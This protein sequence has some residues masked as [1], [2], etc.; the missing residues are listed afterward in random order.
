M[1]QAGPSEICTHRN[2]PVPVPV[3]SFQDKTN[4]SGTGTGAQPR[5]L[6]LITRE[7]LRDT[8]A[9]LAALESLCECSPIEG[10]STSEHDRLWWVTAA[11]YATRT[12]KSPVGLFRYLIQ[13]D[14]RSIPKLCDED[15]AR[16]RLKEVERVECV[17]SIG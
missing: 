15:A 13:G 10:L 11:E 7:T 3:R 1:G 4:R 16:Q 6:D 2:K 9:L 14:R 8:R 5:V 17:G 12:G